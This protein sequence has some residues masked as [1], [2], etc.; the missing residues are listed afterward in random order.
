MSPQSTPIPLFRHTLLYGLPVV[1]YA[2]LIFL[3][4]SLSPFP[5]DRIPFVGYDKLA[6]LVEYFL[7]GILIYRWFSNARPPRIGRHAALLTVLLGLCY[8]VSDEWHQ[9]FIPGRVASAWDV[10]F[11]TLGVVT[12]TFAYP[13]TMKRYPA[14][15]RLDQTIERKFIHEP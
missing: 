4:S 2:G 11:D 10:L 14:L 5:D 9:S 15:Q 3:L 6:H 12:A 1:M 7:F 13:L 8:G